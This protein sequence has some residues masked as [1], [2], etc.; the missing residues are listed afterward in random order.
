MS[1]MPNILILMA[2]QH[3]ADIL[4]CAGDPV[5]RTPNIDRLAAEGIRFDNAY[6][7]GPLCMPA[8]ASF[9]TERY[10]RDHGV[11][12]N[13]WAV[14]VDLPTFLHS[15]QQTGYHT[16]CIG[17]MHLWV[18]GERNTDGT[19]AT[20]D[21]RQRADQMVDY[22]FAEP[23]ETVG[24][25]ATVNIGSEYTDHLAERGL[26]GTY[27]EWVAKRQYGRGSGAETLPNWATGSIPI[28]AEDYIDA[29][30]ADRVVRWLEEYD[31]DEPW[32]MWV[33]F[34][35]PHDPW[36]APAEYVDLYRHGAMPMPGS[37]RRPDIPEDGPFR[38]FLSFF[39]WKHSDSATM[40]DEVIQSVRQH[41]YADV[42][43][44]DDGVARIRQALEKTGQADNT[45]IIYTADHGEM[46]GEHRM[47]MKMVFYEPSVRVPLIIRPPLG[48]DPAVV[49]DLVEHLD[50][51]ATIRAIAGA[52]GHESFEG[53]ALLGG[54]GRLT[55]HRR[56]AVFSEN[57][58]MGM[59]R[60]G[61][62]KLVFHEDSVSPGQLFDL[63][64]DPAEDVNLISDPA[65][66]AVLEE[67]METRVK[68]F[69][70]GGRRRPGPGIFERGRQSSPGGAR[71]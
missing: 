13:R 30:H 41:Y 3:R 11:Y 1:A 71:A 23:I 59:V 64:Q 53:E 48:T 9:L 36:D 21:A 57:Y 60:T 56:E 7:Q 70:G 65:A 8:R 49:T 47:L 10:V 46:L 24:K 27:R 61:R 29:W 33:G 54:D 14:P 40:T 31:R 37:L 34:P 67:L 16:A 58:G 17:K 50:V 39:L 52:P 6:C 25:L 18:H 28:P 22:G 12:E 55:G 44:I 69:I 19:R 42:T 35:G 32:C 15:I 26:L 5:V 43:V 2:D 68:P 20:T 4:G 51:P 63:E 38:D 62:H 66:A 45:W